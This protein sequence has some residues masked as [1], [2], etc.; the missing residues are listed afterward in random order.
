M[1]LPPSGCRRGASARPPS[2]P[3][4]SGSGSVP[5]P[6]PAPPQ[7][8]ELS[9]VLGDRQ[10]GGVGRVGVVDAIEPGEQLRAIDAA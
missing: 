9:V 10:R 6:R 3:L 7:V 2:R 1:P 8:R 5:E 4:S